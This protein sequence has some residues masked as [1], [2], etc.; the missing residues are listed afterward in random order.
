MDEHDG[1]RESIE[2][3]APA[4]PAQGQQLPEYVVVAAYPRGPKENRQFAF[5]TAETPSGERVALAFSTR[6]ALVSALGVSQP[7]SVCRSAKLLE[8]LGSQ[9]VGLGLDPQVPEA[10]PRWTAAD[11]AGLS[12]SLRGEAVE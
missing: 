6:E 8:L 3:G 7:W 5:R 4:G 10:Y 9:G 2:A 12:R 11:L 1:R